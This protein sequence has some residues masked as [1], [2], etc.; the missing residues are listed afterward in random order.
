MLPLNHTT[1]WIGNPATGQWITNLL[2]SIAFTTLGNVLSG[3]VVGG[4]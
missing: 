2:P 3:E 4:P 1:S